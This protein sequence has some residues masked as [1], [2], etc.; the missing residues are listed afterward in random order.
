[1]IEAD[2]QTAKSGSLHYLVAAYILI[3]LG[4]AFNN[5]IY[6]HPAQ[7]GLLILGWVVLMLPLFKNKFITAYYFFRADKLLLL[8]A[9]TSFILFYFFD[10]G[11]YL[12]SRQAVSNIM[13]LKFLALILFFLYFVNFNFKGNNLFSAVILHLSRY[14]FIY[15]VILAVILRMLIIFYSPAPQIDVFHMLQG[16]GET[17]MRGQNPYAAAFTNVYSP[18]ACMINFSASVCNNDKF[19]YFPSSLIF[20]VPAIFLFVDFRFAYIGM[21]LFVVWLMYGLFR[22]KFPAGGRMAE[23]LVLLVLYLP[24]SLLVLEQSWIDQLSVYVLY[25]FVFLLLYNFNFLPYLVL[26]IFLA[27]KQTMLAFSPFVFKLTHDLKKITLAGAVFWIFILPFL[28]W[29]FHEFIGDT[30]FYHVNYKVS[31]F[32]LSLNSIAKTAFNFDLPLAVYLLPLLG[33]FGLLMFKAKRDL[34]GMIHAAAVFLLAFFI[35]RSGFANYYF[36]ILHFIV[37]LIF[38]ELYQFGVDGDSESKV[39]IK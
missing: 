33:L 5:G 8:A 12:Q 34:S 27:S 7:L 6:F 22:K 21:V 9:A 28:F 29:N 32:S 16:G 15:L 36:S 4:Y 3:S 25:I 1:M 35:L 13:V 17:L 2:L 31:A 26:G 30:I 39:N 18:E 10:N 11:I 19:A 37:I 23:L 14:K 38:L 20:I 24:L